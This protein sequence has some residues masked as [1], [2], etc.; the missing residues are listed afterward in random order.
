MA[1]TIFYSWQSDRSS[2]IN[3]NFIEDAIE[4]AIKKV[5][6][7][8]EIQKALRDEPIEFDKDTKDVPG[9][10][11]IVETIFKKI[12]NCSIFIPDLTFV[13]KTEDRRLLPNPNVLIEYGWAL[14]EITHSKIVPVMNTAFGEPSWE[15]LPFDMRHLRH[16]LTYCLREDTSPEE[17]SKIKTELSEELAKAI[18]LIIRN[19]VEDISHGRSLYEPVPSTT[20]LSTFLQPG[21][22][23]DE[24]QRLHRREVKA[25][26]PDNQHLYLRIIPTIPLENIK[27]SKQAYDLAQSGGLRPMGKDMSGLSYG[28]NKYGSYVCDIADGK[29][30]NLTQLFKT[31]EL[32]GIDAYAIDKNI[33]MQHG[34]ITFGFF[35][36]SYLEHIFILTLTNYLKFSSE[37]LHLQLPLQ[38]NVGATDVKGYRMAAPPGMYF[39][40]HEIFGGYVVDDD[41]SYKGIITD[42]DVKAINILH[43]FFEHLWEECGLERPEK[44]EL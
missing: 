16:P 19:S 34:K 14:K 43:P 26:V 40:G 18:E 28:R 30:L 44:E 38:F 41:I 23:F 2:S 22:A 17:R 21:E 13:G 5:G 11:P 6:K 7:D 12:S 24:E 35:Q 27:S 20:N 31:G 9:I 8:I 25:Y 32:W 1:F 3:R 33:L 39:R 29:V 37:I 10:P 36:S 4:K 15:T 42:Y